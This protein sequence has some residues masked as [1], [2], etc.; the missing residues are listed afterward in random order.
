MTGPVGSWPWLGCFWPILIMAG[1]PPTMALLSAQCSY[2]TLLGF[3]LSLTLVLAGLAM[4][5]QLHYGSGCPRLSLWLAL[6]WILLAL[7]LP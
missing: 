1:M 7:A 4:A 2:L 3:G 6:G 5:L